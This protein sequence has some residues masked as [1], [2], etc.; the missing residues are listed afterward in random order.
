MPAIRRAWPHFPP[1][2]KLA[3][4]GAGTAQ[5]LR[6]AGYQVS[7]YPNAEWSSE[8]LLALSEF[9][10]VTGQKIAIVRGEGGRERLDNEFTARG[11]MVLHVIAYQRLLPTVDVKPYQQMLK[12][13]AINA[14]ICG[15]FESVKNLKILLAEEGWPF[16][17]AIPL[18]VTSER[19]KMLANNLGFQTIWIA[20]NASHAA[21][22]ETL[23]LKRNEI[24][25]IKP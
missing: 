8:G 21:V 11:A 4:V 7:A 25:Q 19:I 15:S 9:Q 5:A 10:T 12:E 14:I 17:K 18:I 24:C 22:V 3:A 6:E 20:K 1:Q 13:H 16:L 2:V 23:A